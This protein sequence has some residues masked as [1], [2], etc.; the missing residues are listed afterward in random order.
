M[1]VEERKL[2]ELQEKG[3]SILVE[4]DGKIIFQSS[5]SMLRPLYEGLNNYAEEMQGATVIDKIVGRA[6]AYLC[7]LAKVG[8]VITPLASETAKEVL[9]KHGIILYA[10][11]S[12][13]YII[14]RDGTDMCPMEKMASESVSP[15][16]F[17]ERLKSKV[18]QP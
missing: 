9:D 14:N 12:I 5:K 2:I 6:A 4:K 10:A 17:Y 8:K 18:R 11:D 3:L 15:E 13:P 7:I 16:D 1:N